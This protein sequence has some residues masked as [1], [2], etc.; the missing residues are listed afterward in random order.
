MVEENLPLTAT[1]NTENVSV[2]SASE[3]ETLSE[4][5]TE[6]TL[7]LLRQK[8]KNGLS[9]EEALAAVEVGNDLPVPEL[10]WES[11]LADT[12]N[13]RERKLSVAKELGER[14]PKT[15]G[16]LARASGEIGVVKW[17][18]AWQREAELASER[19]GA[20]ARELAEASA[21]FA[22]VSG[23]IPP[24][25]TLVAIRDLQNLTGA[26]LAVR[27]E[28]SK[29]VFG[30]D[31]ETELSRLRDAVA[32]AENCA[33]HQSMLSLSYPENAWAE[34]NLELWLKWWNEAAFSRA[35]PRWMKRRKV[36]SALRMLAGE[37]S[38]S[39]SDPR[40]D[41]GN[42]I[43]IRVCKKEF[44]ENYRGLSDAYP[45]LLP[46]MK[47]CGASERVAALEKARKAVVAVSQALSSVPEKQDAWLAVLSRWMS[48]EDP[49]FF[50]SGP[51]EKAFDS[52]SKALAE[53][54]AARRALAELLNREHIASS[55]ETPEALAAFAEELYAD[56]ERWAAVCAWNMSAIAAER[57]GMS[58]VADLIRAGTLAAE[59]AV[60]AFNAEYCRR[61][62]VAAA[63]L[64]GCS[65]SELRSRIVEF[66]KKE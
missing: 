35:F 33:R 57:R 52:V 21:G 24:G 27:G 17:N 2:D 47:P 20:A 5:L 44:E 37:K 66:L 9:F 13:I 43:A 45:S 11:P 31:A 3:A 53:V 64:G 42:L 48:G 23:L 30:D 46:G 59:S 7:A 28:D 29:L 8:H 39:P 49:A 51:V 12:F 22:C 16:C 6:E 34:K 14:F 1:E 40:V 26:L 41:L 15:E 56:R 60:R 4:G 32:V 25:G 19:L 62:L 65:R 10:I 38:K 55:C 58:A 61:W 18:S 50:K 63:E 36:V 54:S